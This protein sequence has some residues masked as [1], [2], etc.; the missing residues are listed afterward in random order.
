MLPWKLWI[1]KRL[2]TML[3]TQGFQNVHL[4]V[5]AFGLQ[6]IE[7]QNISIGNE[8]PLMLENIT[9]SYSLADLWHGAINDLTVKGLAL[10]AYQDQDKW[11]VI[12]LDGWPPH[13]P[14]QKSGLAIPVTLAQLAAI[15][16]GSTTLKESHFHITTS[17]WQAELPLL[18]TWQKNP[19]PKLDY[20]VTGLSFKMKDMN[21]ITGD[22]SLTATLNTDE[23]KWDGQWQMKSISLQGGDIALPAMEGSGTLTAYADNFTLDGKF[24][25]ADKKYRAAFN[26]KYTLNNPEK[27][28]FTLT[29]AS[30]P[31]NSGSLS[32]QNV[33]VPLSGKN[34]ININV[35]VQRA[36]VDALLQMLTGKKATATGAVSGTIPLTIAADGA[37]TIRPGGL[38]AEQSGIIRLSPDAIPGDNQ[39]VAMVREILKNLHYTHLSIVIDSNKGNNLSVLLVLEG[40]NPDAYEGRP[41]KLNV[42][43]TGDMLNLIKQNMTPFTNPEQLLK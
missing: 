39:Q 21:V 16:L 22:T 25:S 40:N 1:E 38:H 14:H 35:K 23:K 2:I 28:F 37:I 24:E 26:L 32:A 5:S 34:P 19:I 12:G 20:H 13:D 43:L 9:V 41:V 31:W 29:N 6:G 27:S 36:S 3:E 30:I 4:T 11:T 42:H 33:N 15:P 18:F 7:L 10:E 8:K 17:Q